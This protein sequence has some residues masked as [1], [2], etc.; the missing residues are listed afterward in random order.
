MC[1]SHSGPDL[2]CR[3]TLN[4][5]YSPCWGFTLWILLYYQLCVLSLLR[6]LMN[7]VTMS[8]VTSRIRQKKFAYAHHSFSRIRFYYCLSV[9]FWVWSDK[10]KYWSGIFII[11][12]IDPKCGA[13]I[14]RCYNVDFC[15]IVKRIGETISS[16]RFTH[17]FVYLF[18]LAS[19][20]C[21]I[22]LFINYIVYLY[23]YFIYLW[24]HLFNFKFIAWF[25]L[26]GPR[27]RFR[28]P[29]SRVKQCRYPSIIYSLFPTCAVL[30]IDRQYF[31]SVWRSN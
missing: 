20:K 25:K 13:L 21:F 26:A 15:K 4:N 5:A 28:T 17:S 1:C 10:T 14:L 7:D 23:I 6:Y 30:A 31:N 29:D 19:E 16:F 22:C 24:I 3:R 18:N 11:W 8:I 27:R 2:R 12:L 9:P